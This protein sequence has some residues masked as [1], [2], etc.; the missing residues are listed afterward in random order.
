[1]SATF[2][3]VKWV[4]SSLPAAR[5]APPVGGAGGIAQPLHLQRRVDLRVGPMAVMGDALGVE[6]LEAGGQLDR[7]DVDGL[8]ALLLREVD[9]LPVAADLHAGL[10]ALAA[11]E[12]D[13]GLGV[14]DHQL[15]HGLGE[16]HVDRLVLGGARAGTSTPLVVLL[17]TGLP[18]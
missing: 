8:H 2:P 11:L 17:Y 10:L 9:G 4:P 14:D 1:M 18:P 12:L 13:A 15:G 6:D 5:D 16:G 3:R 7:P